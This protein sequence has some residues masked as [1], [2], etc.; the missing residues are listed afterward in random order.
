MS[1]KA[2]WLALLCTTV[3]TAYVLF[4]SQ[5]SDEMT[6]SYLYL[7]CPLRLIDFS[8]G[9]IAYRIY[10]SQTVEL[11]SAWH[12][13]AAVWQQS[14]VEIA[15]V[16]VIVATYF[17]YWMVPVW[18]RICA[19]FWPGVMLVVLVFVVADRGRGI[20]T[21]LLQTRPLQW[22]GSLSMELYLSHP[23]AFVLF[24]AITK[25]MGIEAG[26]QEAG[27]IGLPFLILLAYALACMKR[28]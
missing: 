26:W 19:L 22:L 12:A 2:R 14:L 18:F 3:L 21:R 17:L 24:V 7:P 16:G 25:R 9:I 13:K 5:V 10:R 15:T 6:N 11:F 4:A 8:L 27:T 23:L 20:V 28:R 1:M